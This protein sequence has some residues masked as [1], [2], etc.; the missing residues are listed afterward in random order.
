MKKRDYIDRVSE[1]ADK[2][3]NMIEKMNDVQVKTLFDSITPQIPDYRYTYMFNVKDYVNEYNRE[4]RNDTILS[5][6][7]LDAINQYYFDMNSEYETVEDMKYHLRAI[8][9]LYNTA[10]DI[11]LCDILNQR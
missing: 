11:L 5:E 7:L 9:K 3:C 2:V 6:V 4:H 10:Q 8:K 1:Y